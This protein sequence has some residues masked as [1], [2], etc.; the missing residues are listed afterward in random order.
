MQKQKPN[1][2][3]ILFT[4]FLVLVAAAMVMYFTQGESAKTLPKVKLSYYVNNSEFASA[5]EMSL[6]EELLKRK[7]FWVG[8]EPENQNQI[9]LTMLIKQQ[10]E[11][12]S[13]HRFDLV[14]IDKELMLEKEIEIGF[15]MTH[16]IALKENYAE[17]AE[18]IKSNKDKR[19]LVVTAAIYST[20]LIKEN[21]YTKVKELTQLQPMAFSLGFLPAVIEEERQ[22]L[23]KC[24]TEDKTG[25]SPWACAVVNKA[26]TIRRRIDLE[27]VKQSWRIGLMDISGEADY[28]VLL[29]K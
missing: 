12:Q 6:R 22:T 8:Y 27:K 28:M 20:N 17:A 25:T 23:F 7:Y 19:I 5:I 21:P 15:D 18:L 13:G 24:D 26:R 2:R 4:I 11:L 10:I 3:P 16:E 14:I 1:Y 9:D 29:G